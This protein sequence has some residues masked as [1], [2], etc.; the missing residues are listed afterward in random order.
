[1]LKSLFPCSQAEDEKTASLGLGFI[2]Y[3]LARVLLPKN[4]LVVG[5]CKGFTLICFAIALK[6][7]GFGKITLIDAGYGKKDQN[8]W[9]GIGF[10]KDARAVERFLKDW[11]IKDITTIIAKRTQEVDL[12]EKIDILYIDADHSYEG[13]KH[14]FEKFSK[15]VEKDG[16]VIM[17]D[18]ICE[19]SGFGVK[20]YFKEIKASGGWEALAIPRDAG[21]GILRKLQ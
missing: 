15:L 18:V 11:R 10:W 20:R 4:V 12:S 9:G 2:Y 8:G 17:H 19:R 6:E 7:N 13:V 3:S 1:M 14:D 5:S 21:A 16:F